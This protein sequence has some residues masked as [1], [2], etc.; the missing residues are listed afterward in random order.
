M[1]HA[2]DMRRW[3]VLEASVET[4]RE[5][6]LRLQGA[7]EEVQRNAGNYVAGRCKLTVG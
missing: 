5:M 1:K 2:K 3:E 6:S 7:A 4:E